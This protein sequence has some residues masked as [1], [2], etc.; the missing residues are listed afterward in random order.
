[1]AQFHLEIG[2]IL[3][4]SRKDS[5]SQI[6]TFFPE[7]KK[8]LD[9]KGRLVLLVSLSLKKGDSEKEIASLGREIINHFKKE[10]LR[11]E[12]PILVGL[13]KAAQNVLDEFG[14]L[15]KVELVVAVSEAGGLG[16]LGLHRFY[17]GRWVSGL[18]WLFT[19]GVLAVGAI[20]DLFMIPEMVRVENLS[21][22]LL[23]QADREPGQPR[24][25]RTVR[26]AVP[27]SAPC[28]AMHRRRARA[29]L[30][31]RLPV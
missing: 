7:D 31:S 13:K 6:Y 9:Q 12:G 1:M 11:A 28:A 19:G 26:P 27:R 20:I 25:R 3:G 24:R 23:Q 18:I 14:D 16:V 17:L 29:R 5:W 10:Y 15:V 4:A 30:P 2:R 8:T 21:R 22:K